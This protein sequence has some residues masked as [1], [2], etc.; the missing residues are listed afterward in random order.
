MNIYHEVARAPLANIR[1]FRRVT[2]FLGGGQLVQPHAAYALGTQDECWGVITKFR[3]KTALEQ[4]TLQVKQ[5]T[6]ES[7]KEG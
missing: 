7:P 3:Q 2:S 6:P 4:L 1:S 5:E